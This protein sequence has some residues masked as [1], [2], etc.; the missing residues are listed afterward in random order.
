MLAGNFLSRINMDLRENK[1]WSY[2]VSGRPVMLE[3]AVP[4][5]V[6]APVQAD[7]T[8]EALAEL[9]AQISEF[10]ATKGVTD[11]ELSAPSPRTST[12]CRGGSKPR[13]QCSAQ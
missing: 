11:E 12:G 10:L 7:K 13:R 8:G 4:Y 1:G 3:N 6:S 2:G 9:N 5:V